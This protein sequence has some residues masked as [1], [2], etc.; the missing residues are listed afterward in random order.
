VFAAALSVLHQAAQEPRSL[1]TLLE[2]S[3][4]VAL[5]TLIAFVLALPLMWKFVYGPITR[6]LE[7]RDQ[8]VEDSIAAAEAARK[9]AEAQV[10]AAKA[11][12][13]KARAEARAMVDAALQRAERQAQEALRTAE[14]KAR[15]QL[16]R[17]RA[18]IAAEKHAALEEVRRHVVD[19]TIQA[20]GALLK[21]KVDDAA[22]R[23]L[24]Q[25]FV[26]AAEAG[27]R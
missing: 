4:G 18:E 13:D 3:P 17:A 21:Q 14:E 10:A 1:S 23:G 12:L 24:V 5:W 26:A 7:A 6:A 15:A 22:H 27:A 20:T 19:L 9:A 11:E 2:F 8:K 16:A 25:E